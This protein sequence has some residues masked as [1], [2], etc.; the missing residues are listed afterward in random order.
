[1]GGLQKQHRMLLGGL[2]KISPCFAPKSSVPTPHTL[3]RMPQE[4]L[5]QT[6]D[7]PHVRKSKT[8]LDPGFNA[9]DSGVQVLDSDF[10]SVELRFWILIIIG[11]PDSL[12]CIPDPNA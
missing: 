2:A 7:S 12:S 9:V 5:T 6:L 3:S 11:I 10:L 8:V 4:L 1:M